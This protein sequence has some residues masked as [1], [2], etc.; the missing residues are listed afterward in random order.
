MGWFCKDA[1]EADANE[2]SDACVGPAV[3]AEGKRSFTCR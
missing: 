1:N 3:S 2:P